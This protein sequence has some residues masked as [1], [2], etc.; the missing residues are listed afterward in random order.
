MSLFHGIQFIDTLGNANGFINNAG[1]PQVCSQ[2]YLQALAEGDIANHSPFEKYG[3]CVVSNALMD[4]WE[5]NSVYAFPAAATQLD[6]VSTDNVNDKA[7]GTGALKVKINGLNGANADTTEEVTL[8]GT[9]IVTTT[10]SFRR[11]NKMWVS[12]AGT[13]GAA[14]GTITAKITGGATVYAQ[15]SPTFTMSRQAIYSVPDGKKIFITSMTCTTGVGNTSANNK[16]N[17]ITFTLR[18]LRDPGTLALST[19][20]Y[21]IAEFGVINNQFVRPFEVP[22]AIPATADIRVQVIGD[23]NQAVTVTC[24][25]RGWIE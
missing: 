5:Q 1:S 18:A 19:I 15:I 11:I 2:D 23:T 21:P 24:A 13:G 20:F 14:V 10:A 9:T 8:N 25:L 17:Y 4:V 12:A 16:A 22:L 3:K 7:G 6:V